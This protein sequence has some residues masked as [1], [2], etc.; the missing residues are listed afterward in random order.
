MTVSF[1]EAYDLVERRIE[2]RYG[3]PVSISDVKDPNTGDFDGMRILVDYNQELETAFFVLVHLFGHT[4]Q[5]NTSAH[6]RELGADLKLNHSEE[7]LQELYQYE[8]DATRYSLSLM[9]DVGIKSLDQWLS[10]YWAAD[11]VYL[12]HFYRTRGERLEFSSLLKRGQGELL[13][14]LSIPE[15]TPQQWISRWSF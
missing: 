14:P 7:R 5:W 12:E 8:R 2:T 15:F 9:H 11:W 3:I 6:Y 1:K 10:D 4:V 13:T